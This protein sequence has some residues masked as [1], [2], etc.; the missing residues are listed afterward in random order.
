MLGLAFVNS[1]VEILGLA[2]V[3]PVIGVVLKPE[4]IQT[5]AML[6]QAF[7]WCQPVGITTEKR[8]IAL[9]AAT[10]LGAFLFKAVF[11]LFVT[12]LQNRLSFRIGLRL[13]GVQWTYHFA[14]SL[15]KMRSK[16]SGKVMA[17]INGWPIIFATNFLAG[18]LALINELIVVSL[19]AIG[20][21]WY[22]PMILLSIAAILAAGV[23]LIRRTTKQRL[24]EY[25]EVQKELEPKTITLISNA[26]RGFLE[27]ITFR[28]SDA[29]RDSYLDKRSHLFSLMAKRQVMM[30]MPAKLYEVLAVGVIAVAIVLA[31]LWEWQDLAFFEFLT[32][33]VLAAYRVM[34]SLSRLNGYVMQ[35]RSQIHVL[36]QMET[37]AQGVAQ[38]ATL[39]GT[40]TSVIPADSRLAIRVDRLTLGYETLP[41]PVI[42][43]L[44]ARFEAG[45]I[46]AIVGASGSGKSTL[47]SALLGLHQPEDGRALV[48]A[49]GQDLDL[50]TDLT[51][52][53]WLAHVGY[54]SQSPFLFAGTLRENLTL[55][56]PGRTLDEAR[57]LDLVDRLGITDCLGDAPLDFEL[58]EGGANLSGGQQQRVALLRALQLD[59]AVLILDEATSALDP[60]ARDTVFDLLREQA[61]RGANVLLVTHD[62][63]IANRCDSVLDLGKLSA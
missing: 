33:M 19:I 32:L 37:G 12:W 20:L 27:V 62:P 43:G 52:G 10:M 6:A 2:V 7:E 42:S 3:L 24:Q 11:G 4:S 56:V 15:E 14:S 48:H 58:N 38:L 50:N 39:H 60:A 26:L 8:F 22:Q 46:H 21:F 31:M 25:S 30:S 59:R 16:Q 57:V 51:Q 34:P 49:D 40:A 53:D 41:E 63:A 13:S 35:M 36:E 61:T 9:L 17:T 47:I 45:A 18:G 54:L 29:V 28:A 55:R 5:N 44:T 1:F 23:A